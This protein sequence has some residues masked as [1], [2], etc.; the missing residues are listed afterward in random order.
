MIYTGER[1]PQWQGH[2]FVGALMEARV[3]GTGHVQRL[4]FN[5]HGEQRREAI[6]RELRQR[7]RDVK[8]GP[9]GLIYVLTEEEDGALLT[10]EP[11]E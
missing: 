9:D 10:I 8:Q 5:E 3:P 4:V 7:I 1:F 2:W 11:A 6:L